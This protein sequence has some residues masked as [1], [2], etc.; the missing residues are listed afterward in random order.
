[1]RRD[2]D[3]ANAPLVNIVLATGH[4]NWLYLK[5]KALT[6]AKISETEQ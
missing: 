4:T 3:L 5:F 6:D 2:F 1:M